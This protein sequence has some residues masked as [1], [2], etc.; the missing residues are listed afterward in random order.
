[1][2]C[3]SKMAQCDLVF[4]LLFS[5][6]LCNIPESR[7]SRHLLCI[8]PFLSLFLSII[9]L[10]SAE[11]CTPFISNCCTFNV[12]IQYPVFFS[13]DIVVGSCF[14]LCSPEILVFQVQAIH[15][16]EQMIYRWIVAARSS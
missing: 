9:S 4:L 10:W 15:M 6:A 1:M 8:Y 7:V 3:Y 13:L 14:F 5:T 16:L 12:L 11:Q 2:F